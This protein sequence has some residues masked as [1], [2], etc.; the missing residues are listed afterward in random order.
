MAE[1]IINT[2]KKLLGIMV[3]DTAFDAD[4]M[5]FINT[6]LMTL[7]Q[8]G[9]GTE[10]VYSVDSVDDKW[11]DFLIDPNAYPAVKSFIYLSVRLAFDPPTNSF[12][13]AS[14]ERQ[15][16]ELTFRLNVQVPIPADL[17]DELEI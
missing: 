12:V 7:N 17:D 6:A 5:V 9:V 1:S 2:I 4:I 3:T 15:L 10:G 14:F 13:I 11:S 8:L 16:A